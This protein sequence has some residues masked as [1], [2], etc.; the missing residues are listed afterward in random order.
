MQRDTS[1]TVWGSVV[2]V[3]VLLLVA[4][5]IVGPAAASAEIGIATTNLER[6]VTTLEESV[7]VSVFLRNS[8]DEGGI[9]MSVEATGWNLAER[10]VIVP[11][12]AEKDV[13]IPVNFDET[14]TYEI[15]L[16]GR[17]VGDLT[18]TRARTAAVDDRENGR[19]VHVRGGAVDAGSEVS[20]DVPASNDTVDLRGATF[21]TDVGAFNGSVTTYES[22]DVAPFTGPDGGAV[23][24]VLTTDA[25]DGATATSVRFAV[26]RSRL[27]EAGIAPDALAV[28][29]RGDGG[30]YE[31]VD[32]GRVNATDE[33]VH[34]E[35]TVESGSSFVLGSLV[36]DFAIESAD[37]ATEATGE[38]KK[39][40][41]SA[42]VANRGAVANDHT[43]RLRIDGALVAQRTVAVEGNGS[44]TV[45]LSHTVT[46]PGTHQAGLSGHDLGPVVVANGSGSS[47][48]TP[49]DGSGD[50]TSGGGVGPDTGGLAGGLGGLIPGPAT[51]GIGASVALL[52]GLLIVVLRR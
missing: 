39:V 31:A 9:T 19:T 13:G 17:R 20:V 40:T 5:A 15:R 45:T 48:A 16:D 18:V 24:G 37:Y 6:S 46:A 22:V 27:S 51:V 28:Y 47:N 30:T 36:A 12:D 49:T 11:A 26:D 10:R 33:E 14:G 4:G 50:D 29:R 43:L 35:A 32:A 38:G 42:T 41:A 2:A 7:N 44:T 21:R 23:V 1:E 34:Y 8:G 52:G 25:P 3:A